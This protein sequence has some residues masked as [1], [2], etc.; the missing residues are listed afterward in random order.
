[1]ESDVIK[2]EVREPLQ[3]LP[4]LKLHRNDSEAEPQQEPGPSL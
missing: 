3:W 2:D 1:M 4:K